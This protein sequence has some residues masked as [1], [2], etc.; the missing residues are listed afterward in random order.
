VAAR[1]KNTRLRTRLTRR[2]RET[3]RE[4]ERQVLALRSPATAATYR[5]VVRAFLAELE[6]P[7]SRI[8]REDV[9]AFLALYRE[10]AP[11]SQARALTALR[12]FCRFLAEAGQLAS[13]PTV[14][15]S[16]RV[17]R[18]EKRVLAT[19]QVARLLRAS[20]DVP[21]D[22]WRRPIALRDRALLELL[23]GLALRRSEAC[24]ARVGDLDLT[25]GELLV[26]R[27]KRGQPA[28]LPLP[29]SALEAL[30]RYLREA[31]PGMVRGAPGDPGDPGTL[32][33][34]HRGGR[35]TEGYASKLVATLGR[36]AGVSVYPHA[37]RR[38]CA[39]HLLEAGVNLRVVQL[40][41]GHTEL[42]TTARYLGLGQGEL[43]RVV[44]KALDITPRE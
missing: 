23:Y 9:A 13:D 42:E 21:P 27:A 16:V 10:L 25:R 44:E 12:S 6:R 19:G 29:P 2:Q 15:L 18:Q 39:S 37:L 43:R 28:R 36:R 30:K 31:R 14:G 3:L 4:F 17:P 41:L 1:T 34:N 32:F 8:R 38:A 24:A 35:L 22:S 26:R 5:P 11:A 20:L 33:L 7:P 40:L